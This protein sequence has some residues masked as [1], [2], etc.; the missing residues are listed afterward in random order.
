[1]C[2]SV[3][4]DQSSLIAKFVVAAVRLLLEYDDY[5]VV[6]GRPC[7]AHSLLWGYFH[8]RRLKK[9][10]RRPMLLLLSLCRRRFTSYAYN[11]VA[12]TR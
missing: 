7:V 6:K 11:V 4:G 5:D 3:R 9:A 2:I 10:R 12:R 1:M 8:L